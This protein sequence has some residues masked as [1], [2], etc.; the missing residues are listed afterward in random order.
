MLAGGKSRR[1]GTDKSLL[2][3]DG[4]W[5]LESILRQLATLSQDV[6]IVAADGEKLPRLGVRVVPDVFPGRGPL[7]G[8]HAGLQAMLHPRGL[9]VACD[10]PLLNLALLR[11]MILVSDGYDVVIP[12]IG[13]YIEPLHAIYHKACVP[14]IVDALDHGQHRPAGF[15]DQVRVRYVDREEI[16]TFDPQHLSFLNIN[17]PDD[18]EA[19]ERLLR[20]RLS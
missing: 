1:L 5:L 6:L 7:G 3:I 13:Q 20:R 15:L 8:I 11:Y 9:V 10:M 19:A 2:Q 18:L 14:H 4:E 16:E 17:G 12:R